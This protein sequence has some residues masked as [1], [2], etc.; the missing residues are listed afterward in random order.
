[1]FLSEGIDS[2][3]PLLVMAL[4]HFYNNNIGSSSK[5]KDQ[6]KVA[7]EGTVSGW[8]A[9]VGIIGAGLS[10]LACASRLLDYNDINVRV[11]EADRDVG[12]LAGYTVLE[13]LKIAKTYHHVVKSDQVLQ[14]ELKRLRIPIIWKEVN[15][16]TYAD[17]IIYPMNGA[18]DL[19]R[20]HPLPFLDRLRLGWLVFRTRY[21]PRLNAITV[22]DWV[23]SGAG[24]KVLVRFVKPLL[25]KY[26]GSSK[27]VSAAYLASRWHTESRT[28]SRNL[29]CS[30]FAKLIDEYVAQITS[31]SNSMLYTD[32]RVQRVVVR[33]N[34]VQIF[35]N[36][37]KQE[38]LDVVVISTPA[39]EA[40]SIIEGIPANLLGQLDSTNYR[41]V[42]CLVLRLDER[43]SNYYW[44]NVLDYDIPF[45]ACFEFANLDTALSGGLVYLVAYTDVFSPL[46]LLRDEEIYERFVEGL[47]KIFPALPAIKTWYLFRNRF[48]SPVYTTGY[49]NIEVNPYT[50]I[51]FAGVW[52]AFPEIRNSGAAIMTGIEV[53]QKIVEQV[54]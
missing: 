15:I 3:L 51:Y 20:F 39:K 43:I 6:K 46:W 49:R 5:F 54:R 22:D 9:T 2:T 19:L 18:F 17:S 29:G 45:V 33:N 32:C 40:A 7:L 16:G 1:M 35:S 28:A 23:R 48:G 42:L 25:T 30:N 10:G 27:D 44:I 21:E 53:A 34:N 24:E 50:R 13:N 31:S 12:G 4:L 36:K 41:A 26:F 37:K 11:F 52:R 8:L 14:H 38:D 47:R